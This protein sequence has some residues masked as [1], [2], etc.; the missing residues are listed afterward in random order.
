[1]KDQL[2]AQVTQIL[3]A[4][5]T[6]VGELKDFSLTELPDIAQQY[7]TYGIWINT[8]YA[9]AWGLIIV[10]L[11]VCCWGIVQWS[12]RQHDNDILIFLLF[13]V[14]FLIFSGA[15]LFENIHDLILIH[16]APKVW[17][18]LEIKNLLS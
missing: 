17:F 9:I 10:G 6:S 13:P 1:M 16:N 3:A 15:A 14:V 12:K 18:I 7:I 2:Q 4:I 5:M 8:F 11:I